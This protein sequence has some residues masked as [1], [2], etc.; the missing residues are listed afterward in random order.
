MMDLNTCA[1]KDCGKPRFLDYYVC[2]EHFAF[3]AA[4]QYTDSMLV[5]VDKLEPAP[6]PDFSLYPEAVPC[7]ATQQKS[8]PPDPTQ[9]EATKRARIY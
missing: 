9:S 3:Y 8:P 2:A 4:P 6:F 5:K 1:A 7:V